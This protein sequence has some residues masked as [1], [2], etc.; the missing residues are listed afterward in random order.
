MDY[1]N[2]SFSWNKSVW[3]RDNDGYVVVNG[4]DKNCLKAIEQAKAKHAQAGYKMP[5]VITFA[6]DGTEADFMA[7]NIEFIDGHP[8]F[9]IYFNTT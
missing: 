3:Y 9:D 1:E 2:N 5:S 4:A 7:K 6:A 8:A